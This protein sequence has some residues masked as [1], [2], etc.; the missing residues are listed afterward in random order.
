ML[1]K[2]VSLRLTAPLLRPSCDLGWTL[3]LLLYSCTVF[4]RM[5]SSVLFVQWR[6]LTVVPARSL[7]Q[8]ILRRGSKLFGVSCH[9]PKRHISGTCSADCWQTTVWTTPPNLVQVTINNATKDCFR[10]VNCEFVVNRELRLV[11]LVRN[12][13]KSFSAGG[14]S[15]LLT[16]LHAFG[17]WVLCWNAVVD[18]FDPTTV[19][20]ANTFQHEQ[21]TEVESEKLMD[22]T[23]DARKA[24]IQHSRPLVKTIIRKFPPLKDILKSPVFI[25]CSASMHCILCK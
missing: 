7:L 5:H 9:L 13:Q 21:L 24:W 8:A 10:L 1:N 18:D 12:L 6:S 16:M 14:N 15:Q 19:H 17:N 2:I 11:K 23:F 3:E 20:A 22:K 4:S 25:L